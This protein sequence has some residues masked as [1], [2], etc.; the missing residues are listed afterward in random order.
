MNDIASLRGV[1]ESCD[2][3]AGVGMQTLLC[4]RQRDVR[5]GLDGVG[6]AALPEQRREGQRAGLGRAGTLALPGRVHLFLWPAPPPVA[7][8]GSPGSSLVSQ[9]PPLR[10]SLTPAP[11]LA[12]SSPDILSQSP[13]AG[14]SCRCLHG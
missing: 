5:F 1:D 8:S 3:G 14:L 13:F 7:R 4:L 2:V 12:S 9:G 11:S 6:A 10:P